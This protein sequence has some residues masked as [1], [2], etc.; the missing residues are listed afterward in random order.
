MSN[1][2]RIA[3]NT[4]LLYIRMFFVMAISFYT[5]RLVLMYLGVEDFGIYN[6][7]GGIVS[8]FSFLNG[9]MASSTQRYLT[10]ELEA[11]DNE[12]L[13]VVFSISLFI[14]VIIG[15]SILILGETIGLWFL[16]TQMNIPDNRFMAAVWVYQFAILNMIVLIISVPYYAMIIA[17]E[18]MKVFTYIS[19]AE[20]F[21][22]LLIVVLLAYSSF[23]NLILYS[24]LYFIVQFAIRFIY[25]IYCKKNF[26]GT[27][28]KRFKYDATLIK[29]MTSFAGWNLLSNFSYITF[30]QGINILLN[31]FFGP[32]VNAARGIATMVQGV[33]SQFTVNFQ[34]AINPQ[35]TKSYASKNFQYMYSLIFRSS[36]FTFFLLYVLCV[37]VFLETNII[38]DIWLKDVPLYTVVFLRLILITSIFDAIS[39]PI[40][41]SAMATGKVKMFEIIVSSI[42]L[43]I[44]PSSY[45]ILK[46]GGEP[47]TVF[48]VHIFF[49]IIAYIARLI[50][51]R[52]LIDLSIREY[53]FKV[54]FKCLFVI[55][56]SIPLPLYLKFTLS[57]HLYSFFVVSGVS[58][59][60]SIIVIYFV[61]LDFSEKKFVKTTIIDLKRFI[62]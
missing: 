51:I 6:V 50:I 43:L 16:N 46:L 8:T 22:K 27:E 20:V 5:S 48:I 56:L 1:N 30:S 33:I 14:H 13:R 4:F 57:D 31:I 9:A 23:D 10:F 34:M 3:K 44:L 45:L 55:A 61:G 60:S 35:I 53:V 36:K 7:V 28:I 2:N 11:G 12:K 24:F 29:E 52:K 62:K 26:Q 39:N 25:I 49:E 32:V 17:H 40:I 41:I 15:L 38:L 47:Y 21:F 42:F 37:P 58:V 54:I 18:K 19:V 59:I